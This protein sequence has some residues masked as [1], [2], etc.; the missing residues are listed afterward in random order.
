KMDGAA[1]ADVQKTRK[2][3]PC[4]S[5]RR[6][7]ADGELNRCLGRDPHIVS[8][9]T[10]GVS[11]DA[12]HKIELIIAA[13][14][15]PTIDEELIEPLA[16]SPLH[17][18]AC[19]ELRDGQEYAPR[20]KRQVEDRQLENR[21]RIPLLERVE[22][23]AIPDVHAIGGDKADE[24]DKQKDSGQ[25]PWRPCAALS[26]KTSGALPEAP[27]QGTRLELDCLFVGPLHCRSWNL[28]HLPEHLPSVS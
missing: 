5:H 6:C 18:H 28:S 26:P 7:R 4:E 8:D 27:Q 10:F 2:K 13:V 17:R 25:N 21:G 19:P 20:Q 23:D 12:T 3:P 22:N 9:T 15:E 14:L 11:V 24:D 16:P 1:P